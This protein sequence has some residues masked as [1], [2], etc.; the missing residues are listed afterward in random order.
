VNFRNGIR[1]YDVSRVKVKCVHV[2]DRVWLVVCRLCACECVL[3]EHRAEKLN[4]SRI[5]RND[6][7]IQ[8]LVLNQTQ[9]GMRHFRAAHGGPKDNK[10]TRIF[11]ILLDH[12][13]IP[14]FVGICATYLYVSKT[15]YSLGVWR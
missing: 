1:K 9:D 5:C 6:Y 4:V 8:G 13:G 15:P 3:V 7:C 14:L 2:L 12:S 10:A 11:C